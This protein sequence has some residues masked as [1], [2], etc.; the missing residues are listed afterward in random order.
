[1]LSLKNECVSIGT[2]CT[3]LALRKNKKGEFLYYG[4]KNNY[5]TVAPEH[6]GRRDH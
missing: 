6:G 2:R 5:G 3:F 4:R 1:M